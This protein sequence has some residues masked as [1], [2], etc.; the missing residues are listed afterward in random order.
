MTEER[1]VTERRLQDEVLCPVAL[2]LGGAHVCGYLVDISKAG[3]KFKIYDVERELPLELEEE[4][5]YTIF[6]NYGD[7]Q[8]RAK[9]KWVE[10]LNGDYLWG[11]QFTEVSEDEEDP[12][13]R[14]IQALP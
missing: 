3:A 14:I 9:T 1:R 10:R 7:S 12:L 13:R 5:E 11:V 4:I 2:E 6:T 8:C